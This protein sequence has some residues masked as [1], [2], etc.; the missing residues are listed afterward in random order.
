MVFLNN[1]G[2]ILT[3]WWNVN[4]GKRALIIRV[5][6]FY[7]WNYLKYIYFLKIIFKIIDI[8]FLK[9]D[10]RSC[11]ISGLSLQKSWF[12]SRRVHLENVTVNWN[13]AWYFTEQFVSP[14]K[15]IPLLLFTRILNCHQRHIRYNLNK[16]ERP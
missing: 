9:N 5:S 11:P 12:D 15:I 16:R 10:N 1:V 7:S 3:S 14:F 2:N 13:W 4:F 8:I 6:Y